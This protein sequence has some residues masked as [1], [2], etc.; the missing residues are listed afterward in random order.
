MWI[1][2]SD[3]IDFIG[4]DIARSEITPQQ[5]SSRPAAR[6]AGGR[7]GWRSAV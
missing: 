2:R 1:K 6:A 5:L 4:D 3:R 7:R